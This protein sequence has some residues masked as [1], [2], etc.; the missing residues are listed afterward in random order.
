[1]KVSAQH[2]QE[3]WLISFQRETSTR[4][5]STNRADISAETSTPPKIEAR[6][7]LLAHRMEIGDDM[8]EGAAVFFRIMQHT[9]PKA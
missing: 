3:E 1:M 2:F 7:P 4:T 5:T 8:A 6:R 9:C